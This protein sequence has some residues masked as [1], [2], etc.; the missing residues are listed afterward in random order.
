LFRPYRDDRSAL[1]RDIGKST[2]PGLLAGHNN[3]R[4]TFF[5]AGHC[6]AGGTNDEPGT[7]RH[8]CRSTGTTRQVSQ[9]VRLT[10]LRRY[11]IQLLGAAFDPVRK[12]GDCRAIRRPARSGVVLLATGK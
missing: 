5:L 2:R 9:P 8:P 11:D 12:E 4:G 7:V 1:A 3:F 6:L 10:A